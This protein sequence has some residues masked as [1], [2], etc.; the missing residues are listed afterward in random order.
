MQI[1]HIETIPEVLAV[2]KIVVLASL[3]F[4]LT[5]VFTPLWAHILYKYKIGIKIK[6]KSVD[7]KKLTFVGKLHSHKN[8]T[9]TMGGVLIW[10]SVIILALALRWLAPFLSEV[11]HNVWISR[12]DFVS[13]SQTWLPLFALL[14]TALLGLADDWMSIKGIGGNKGGGMQFTW[15][16]I[17]LLTFAF[18]GA[19]W[20]YTK[21]GWSTIHIPAM[22][23]LEIGAWYIPLFMFI[24]AATAF[25]SNEA[26]GLDGLN[27][28]IL[29]Q[30]FTAFAVIAF[31][32]GRMD[33]AG[34]CGAVAGAL[35][36]FLWFN[37]YPARFFMGDT[38][39]F[40]LGATLGVVALLLNS[41]LVLPFLVSIYLAETLS[42]FIQLASKKFLGKKVFL[43]A[44][45]HHHFEALGWPETK[46]T[47]RF[48]ILNAVVAIIGLMIGIVGGG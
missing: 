16:M 5:M 29:I 7:G 46:V 2:A 47:V 41:V 25:S 44:P 30:A 9:P 23:D 14:T 36:A 3:S 45:I 22:G 24:V 34:F 21:L 28:G 27:A 32:Q 15:R 6:D 42:V 19:W 1:A 20:F 39:A 40:S 38:G 13:R 18:L 33:L 37:F 35:L 4:A 10:G 8:G 12:L 17:W 48:W 26:D 43:A 31:F 11:F